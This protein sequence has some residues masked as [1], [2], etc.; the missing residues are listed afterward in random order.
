MFF[1]LSYAAKSCDE[2]GRIAA[3]LSG[4]NKWL[5]NIPR[6]VMVARYDTLHYGF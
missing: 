3:G 4:A 2:I 6:E 1:L 5:T